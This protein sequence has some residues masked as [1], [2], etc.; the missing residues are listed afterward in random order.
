MISYEKGKSPVGAICPKYYLVVITLHTIGFTH[1]K[2]YF[3]G[4]FGKCVVKVC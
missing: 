4:E 2:V 1:Q 3:C